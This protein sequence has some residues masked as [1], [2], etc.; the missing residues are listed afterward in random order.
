MELTVVTHDVGHVQVSL[1]VTAGVFSV[2]LGGKL[3]AAA[4]ALII[5]SAGDARIVVGNLLLILQG[6]EVGVDETLA[7]GL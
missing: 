5:D 2:T 3:Q 6:E 4:E 7:I 1:G